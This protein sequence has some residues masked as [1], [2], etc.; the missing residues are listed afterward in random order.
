MESPENQRGGDHTTPSSRLHDF[1]H[2][3]LRFHVLNLPRDAQEILL[4][5]GVEDPTDRGL[6][7]TLPVH[8]LYTFGFPQVCLEASPAI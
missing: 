1:K 8:T 4:K 2:G 5:V 3:P 6:S 7:L